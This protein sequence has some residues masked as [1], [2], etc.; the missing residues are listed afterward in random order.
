MR[1]LV[2]GNK[3]IGIVG[4]VQTEGVI[5][6]ITPYNCDNNVFKDIINYLENYEPEPMQYEWLM[7]HKMKRAINRKLRVYAGTASQMDKF[8]DSGLIDKM[9]RNK[10]RRKKHASRITHRSGRRQLGK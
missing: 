4:H 8:I 6:V 5:S 10:N 1:C 3:V 9:D 2:M 7:G